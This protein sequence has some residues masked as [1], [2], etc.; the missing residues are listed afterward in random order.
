M[1]LAWVARPM[2]TQDPP[3][4]LQR[5]HWKRYVFGGPLHEPLLADN[6]RPTR[7][8]PKTCGVFRVAGTPMT[9]R[10]GLETAAVVA[11]EFVA[12]TRDSSV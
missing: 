5:S 1:Y 10:L 8:L 11:R 12:E 9:L 4:R 7:G 2:W 6:C 3:P